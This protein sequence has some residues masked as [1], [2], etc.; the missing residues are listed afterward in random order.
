MT[1]TMGKG[2]LMVRGD[3]G[4]FREIEGANVTISGVEMQSEKIE[5]PAGKVEYSGTM[6]LDEKSRSNLALYYTYMTIGE[7]AIREAV[8]TCFQRWFGRRH[9]SRTQLLR[10]DNPA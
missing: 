6:Q 5:L 3:D 10:R 9:Y 8:A 1:A 7:P 2:K 4:E